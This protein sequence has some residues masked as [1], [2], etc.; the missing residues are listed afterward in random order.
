M[1]CL[2]FTCAG[3]TISGTPKTEA[4]V[5]KQILFASFGFEHSLERAYHYSLPKIVD[6]S[7]R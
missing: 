1:A 4:S 2:R 7:A 5:Y 6:L 3:R